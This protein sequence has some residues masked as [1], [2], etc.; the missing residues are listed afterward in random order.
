MWVVGSGQLIVGTDV[1]VWMVGSELQAA[2]G[3]GSG[4]GG[5]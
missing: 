2:V 5:G 4:S 3:G 1:E